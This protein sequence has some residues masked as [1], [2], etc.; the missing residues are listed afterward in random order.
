M[1]P[2]YYFIFS[3]TSFRSPTVSI[4]LFLLLIKYIQ[5]THASLYPLVHI[6][7]YNHHTSMSSFH[8]LSWANILPLP[9]VLL[10]HQHFHLQ[11][12]NLLDFISLYI[13]FL[14]LCVI[15]TIFLC[16]PTTLL[17]SL[18]DIRIPSFPIKSQSNMLYQS[19]TPYSL[20]TPLSTPISP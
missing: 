2:F 10:L 6:H 3:I 7:T 16:S 11:N 5:I 18:T 15:E 13:L 9:P 8:S 17:Y 19:Q 4:F 14:P 20:Q 1:I 12:I